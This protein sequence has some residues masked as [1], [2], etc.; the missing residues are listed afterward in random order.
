MITLAV[1]NLIVPDPERCPPGK[2]GIGGTP[3]AIGNLTGVQQ[4]DLKDLGVHTEMYVDALW[5]R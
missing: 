3:N 5:T 1:A 4:S 2:I